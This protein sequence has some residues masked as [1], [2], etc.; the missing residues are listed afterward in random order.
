MPINVV[1]PET[2]NDELIVVMLF[3]VVFPE[4]FND[5]LIV[6]ILFNVVFPETFN[7]ELIVVILFK[8]AAEGPAGGGPCEHG[9]PIAPVLVPSGDS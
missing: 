5:E 9:T 1:F 2:F 7:D 4:T 6:V 3:N 8:N